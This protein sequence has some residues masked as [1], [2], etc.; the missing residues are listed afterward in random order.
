L[1]SVL[2]VERLRLSNAFCSA[3]LVPVPAVRSTF[4]LDGLDVRFDGISCDATSLTYYVCTIAIYVAHCTL[5]LYRLLSLLLLPVW[6]LSGFFN[7]HTGWFF[8][9]SPAVC[10]LAFTL[11]Y[12][13]CRPSP[14]LSITVVR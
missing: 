10:G 12:F 3:A 8:E 7:A 4:C 13:L 2:F 5:P 14:S 6:L 9:R 11:P 1:P